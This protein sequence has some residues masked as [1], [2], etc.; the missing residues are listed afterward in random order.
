MLRTFFF[1]TFNEL[2]PFPP[3][4]MP[5]WHITFI[6]CFIEQIGHNVVGAM[7]CVKCTG[8]VTVTPGQISAQEENE[9]RVQEWIF[10]IWNDARLSKW[11]SESHLHFIPFIW[12]HIK[13]KDMGME[14]ESV[15]WCHCLK[16]I[17]FCTCWLEWFLLFCPLFQWQ[18]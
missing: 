16:R 8:M 13:Q 4:S 17:P 1:P 11:R 3:F 15:H 7:Q 6:T 14:G 10:M 18:C 9:K 12:L 5:T 2:S